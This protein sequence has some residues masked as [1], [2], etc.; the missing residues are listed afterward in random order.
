MESDQPFS[1]SQ[2]PAAPAEIV[3]QPDFRFKPEFRLAIRGCDTD[4]DSRFL[5]RK[6]GEPEP[7]VAKQRWAHLQL[8]QDPDNQP[9]G[10]AAEDARRHRP[11]D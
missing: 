4:M 3:R 1:D 2:L 11:F 8:T 9:E 10:W 7:V 5:P 6:E